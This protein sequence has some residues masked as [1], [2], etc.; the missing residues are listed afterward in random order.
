M[1][2]ISFTFLKY[3]FTVFKYGERVYAHLQPDLHDAADWPL[4]GMS[5]VPRANAARIST[6]FVGRHQRTSGEIIIIRYIDKGLF[7]S[8]SVPF[9]LFG[10]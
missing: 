9:L 5:P 8:I 2:I 1:K 6:Q 10:L 7:H 4:V 3:D